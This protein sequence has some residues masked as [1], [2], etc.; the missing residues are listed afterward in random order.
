[1]LPG[2][3]MPWPAFPPVPSFSPSG[4]RPLPP[5]YLC[6]REAE[7]VAWL[8][9]MDSQE[10]PPPLPQGEMEGESSPRRKALGLLSAQPGSFQRTRSAW[11][12]FLPRSFD[13]IPTPC[14]FCSGY[15]VKKEPPAQTSEAHSIKGGRQSSEGGQNDSLISSMNI[16][17]CRDLVYDSEF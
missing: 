14:K 4:L 6:L 5:S 9:A 15:K 16:C 2:P 13:A 12:L 8:G 3:Q 17:R 1:M 11:H 10:P 7:A